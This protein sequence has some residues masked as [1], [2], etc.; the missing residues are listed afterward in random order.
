ML[1][2]NLQYGQHLI[3]C[4]ILTFWHKYLYNI[5]LSQFFCILINVILK[6]IL[7]WFKYNVDFYYLD[8]MHTHTLFCKIK[9]EKMLPNS[10]FISNVNKNIRKIYRTI[11]LMNLHVK[12]LSKICYTLNSRSYKSDDSSLAG[13]LH[14][15]DAK[16]VKHSQYT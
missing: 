5:I 3:R 16:V 1:K 8:Y 10:F 9:K 12:I 4:Y 7:F 2:L 13:Y 15:I 6:Y 14:S 11:S